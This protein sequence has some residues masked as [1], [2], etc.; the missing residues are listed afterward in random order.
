M[1]NNRK[2]SLIILAFFCFLFSFP[3][4]AKAIV[5]PEI[6]DKVDLTAN[7]KNNTWINAAVF[8][9]FTNAN[10]EETTIKT[11]LY[12]MHDKDNL[13]VGFECLDQNPNKLISNSRYLPD[14]DAVFFVLDTFHDGLAAYAFGSNPKADKLTGVVS[15]YSPH[16]KFAF[17]AD[18]TVVSQRTS[19][20]YNVAMAI[21][22]KS[23][24]YGWQKEASIM[25][26]RAVRIT[27]Q[28]QEFN[29]PHIRYDQPGSALIQYQTIKLENIA[30]SNYDKPWFDV[31]AIFN[32]R[33]KLATG[34]DLNTFIGRSEGWGITDGSVADY[35][36]F[37]SH[38]LYPSKNPT[39]L[40]TSLKPLW[41]ENKFKNIDFYPN[42]SIGNLDQFL[43]RTQTTSF[44]VIY[45][46][47]IIYEKY[48]NGFNGQSIAPAFSMTK[49]FLSALVGI[50]IDKKQIESINDPIT[51]YLPELL[52]QNKKFAKIKIK[53]LLQMS[54]GLRAVD[55]KPY[56]DIRKAYFSPNLRQILLQTLDVIELPG[57][58]FSYNDYSAQLVGLI[59]MRATHQNV[60]QLL[61]ARFRMR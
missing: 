46:N 47:K 49:S 12:L 27:H 52:D 54:A 5:V 25:G 26:F 61:Q 51:K 30:R 16:L 14:G 23:I 38:T 29:Y 3:G 45:N 58:H 15:D 18:F 36:I 59:L 9:Q 55:G 43:K 41:V 44:I 40:K 32:A 17:S 7:F 11:K 22:L 2:I 8:T 53:D 21:P 60:T 48:F 39:R 1:I 31:H 50:A 10:G 35:K 57:R 20:G 13:Y 6:T 33:K 4:Y 19:D 24:P 37:P 42:R 34:Y 56:D 28:K